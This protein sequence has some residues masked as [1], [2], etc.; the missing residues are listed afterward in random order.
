[1]FNMEL[2]VQTRKIFGEK[3]K[4]LR[5]QGLIPAE[6]YGHKLDNLHLTVP[7]KEFSRIFKEAGESTVIKLRIENL[8][9]RIEGK[10][11]DNEIEFNVLVHDIDKNAL[12]DEINHIDFYA[13]KKGEKIKV[14]APLRFI[15]ESAAV[16]EKGAILIKA[17]H[18]L[19]IEA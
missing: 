19:E 4:A 16:K 13:V 2:T 12:T 10:N 8:E 6:L 7:R 17:V 15:G 11:T 5:E 3:V 1:M 14:R 9:S 18:E